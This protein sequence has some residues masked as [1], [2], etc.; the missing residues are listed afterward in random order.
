MQQ[1]LLKLR[2]PFTPLYR[3][4]SPSEVVVV[5]VVVG[6]GGCS[7]GGDVDEDGCINYAINFL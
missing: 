6:G 5:V 1:A 4:I 2:Y 3:V 7:G